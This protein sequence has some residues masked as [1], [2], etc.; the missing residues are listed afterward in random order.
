MLEQTNKCRDIIDLA[1]NKRHKKKKTEYAANNGMRCRGGITWKRKKDN[2][3]NAREQTA[4]RENTCKQQRNELVT[5]HSRK[6]A[7][8]HESC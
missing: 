5:I 6:G 8:T 4:K 2:M 1:L 3:K 7:R